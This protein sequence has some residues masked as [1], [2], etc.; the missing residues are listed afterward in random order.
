MEFLQ[1]RIDSYNKTKRT[2]QSL[3]RSTSGNTK[4]PHPTSYIATP[5]T[6]SE[7]GFYFDPGPEHPDNTTCFMCGKQ[8]NSWEPD[9]DPFELHYLKCSERCA[10]ASVRCGPEVEKRGE[11]QC[12]VTALPVFPL[13]VGT[14]FHFA[15]SSR[16]PASKAMEKAR[17]DTFTKRNRWPHD[18]VKGHGANSQQVCP[19]SR[20]SNVRW[21]GRCSIDLC[22][23]GRIVWRRCGA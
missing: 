10:W 12:V 8:L 2:K 23:T 6:L 16:V 3:A 15:D 4:W 1:S 18:A 9:D 17:L 7:A 21:E 13:T 14:R 5:R 20:V 11:Q 22:F 19:L